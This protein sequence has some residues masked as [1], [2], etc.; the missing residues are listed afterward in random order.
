MLKLC[1]WWEFAVVKDDQPNIGVH[2][3]TWDSMYQYTDED[4]QIV[5]IWLFIMKPAF[6]NKDDDA[7]VYGHKAALFWMINAI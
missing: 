6:Q 4:Q 5:V 7:V 1:K 3:P 2:K